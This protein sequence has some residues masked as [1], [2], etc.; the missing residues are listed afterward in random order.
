VCGSHVSPGQSETLA[1]CM[2]IVRTRTNTFVCLQH[3][4]ASIASVVGMMCFINLW[5]KEENHVLCIFS[6]SVRGS[7]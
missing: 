5:L 1:G 3:F 6:C 2:C 7:G 4:L